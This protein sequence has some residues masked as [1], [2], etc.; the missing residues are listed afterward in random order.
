MDM[1]R[2]AMIF[3]LLRRGVPADM[4]AMVADAVYPFAQLGDWAPDRKAR[5][6]VK[7]ISRVLASKLGRHPNSVPLEELRV[8]TRDAFSEYARIAGPS[9]SAGQTFAQALERPELE[10]A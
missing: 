3:S 9:S 2:N 8:W 10:T 6:E 5:N 4:A 1:H 7:G